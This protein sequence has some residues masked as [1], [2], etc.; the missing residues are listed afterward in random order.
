MSKSALRLTLALLS[1]IAAASPACGR[2]STRTQ[3]AERPTPPTRDP[4][5]PGYAGARD[6]P[7][8]SVPPA[9]ADGDF[10]VGPGHTAAPELSRPESTLEGTVIE[11]TMNSP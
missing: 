2:A 8:G 5:S 6:L 10:V 11:F 3:A 4:H 1:M 7:D 9:N